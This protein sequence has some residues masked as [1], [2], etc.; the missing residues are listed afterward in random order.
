MI[1]ERLFPSMF[2]RRLLL[3]CGMVFLSLCAL[4]LKLGHLTVLKASTLR[5]QAESRLSRSVWTPTVRGRI[6][7]RKGR[8]LAQDRAS[9][10]VGL[11]YSVI[12]GA[13]PSERA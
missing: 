1:L 11:D 5:T 3:L 13:W 4:G 6:L 9:Y 7:D 10:A 8:V 2:Q 12:S